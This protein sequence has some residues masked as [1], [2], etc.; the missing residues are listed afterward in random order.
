MLLKQN[1]GASSLF[2][3]EP[4][5]DTPGTIDDTVRGLLLHL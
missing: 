4:A 3:L 1:N 2:S 5:H